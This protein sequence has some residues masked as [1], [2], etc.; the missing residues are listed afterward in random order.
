MLNK[1]R[2]EKQL[3]YSEV[4]RLKKI[5]RKLEDENRRLRENSE[6]IEEYRKEYETLMKS[7]EDMQKRYGEK[8]KMFDGLSVIYRKELGR[9]KKQIE[10]IDS[11]S[12]LEWWMMK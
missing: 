2:T 7:V 5:N 11:D 4:E 6:K 8:L 3:L 9:L 12:I 1:G 10:K